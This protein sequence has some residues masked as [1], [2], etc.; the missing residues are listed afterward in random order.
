MYTESKKQEEYLQW[1]KAVFWSKGLTVRMMSTKNAVVFR[2]ILENNC[3]C[4]IKIARIKKISGRNTCF[5]GLLN[6]SNIGKSVQ[7]CI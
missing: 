4:F 2:T 7:N 3:L 5:C 1:E 6:H